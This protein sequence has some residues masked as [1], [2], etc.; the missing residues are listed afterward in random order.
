MNDSIQNAI[1]TL[2][3]QAAA[4]EIAI[5]CLIPLLGTPST[6]TAAALSKP[7]IKRTAKTLVPAAEP[8]PKRKYAPRKVVAHTS[9]ALATA[10]PAAEIPSG[11]PRSFAGA[12][13]RVVREATVPPTVAMIYATIQTRW[14]SLAEGKDAGNVMANLSYATS[15][16]KCEKLGMGSLA[17]FRVLDPAYF[18]ETE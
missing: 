15:Q 13:K 10:A 7:A 18:Q 12:I 3:N 8:K 4:I 9:P 2:K 17:T 16:G 5:K 1:T 14:P 11:S 6:A